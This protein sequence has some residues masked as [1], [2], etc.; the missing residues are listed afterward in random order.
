MMS[1]WL[2]LIEIKLSPWK[3]VKR[4][5]IWMR[6]FEAETLKKCISNSLSAWD[7]SKQIY[8]KEHINIASQIR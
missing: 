2:K 4:M 3:L 8:V 6:E 7:L 5:E 1:K